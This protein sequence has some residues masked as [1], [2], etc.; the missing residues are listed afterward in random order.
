MNDL[1][2]ENHKCTSN[3]NQYLFPL[4]WFI[5]LNLKLR[6]DKSLRSLIL[7]IIFYLLFFMKFIVNFSLFRR[8]IK[9]SHFDFLTDFGITYINNKFLNNKTKIFILHLPT[10]KTWIDIFQFDI[11]SNGLSL[12]NKKYNILG[13]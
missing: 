4:W 2:E 3:K 11:Q 10:Y 7:M 6:F 9:P 5:W 1:T 13:L 8:P 12:N